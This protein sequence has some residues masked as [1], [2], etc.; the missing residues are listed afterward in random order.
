[1]RIELPFSVEYGTPEVVPIGEVI[2]SL[3]SIRTLIEE[4]G[5]NLPHFVDGLAVE[6]V[7][8]Y[9][10]SV[11]Q[12]SP[13]REVLFVAMFVAFQ[14]NLEKEVP[15]M[16]QQLTGTHVPEQFHTLI[17]LA[18]MIVLFYGVAYVRDVITSLH[19]DSRIK[20]QLSALIAE[21]AAMTGK[22]EEEIRKFLE[23]RY[24]VQGRAKALANAAIRFFRPSKSQADAP[25]S[26]GGRRIDSDIISDVPPEYAY[27]EALDTP[28]FREFPSV[29]LELHA[30]DRDRDQTGWAAIP[31]GISDKRLKMRLLD[32]VSPNEIWGKNRIK[33]DIVVKYDRNGVDLRAAEIH[34]TRVIR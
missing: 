30:Q 8:I 7:E 18:V 19:G 9:V 22:P 31:K 20:R 32:G 24:K 4:G 6:Q 17:T 27:D 28:T 33:G 5:G 3:I 16:I 10:R 11:S 13:L 34:L 2:D 29:E 12:E 23:E 1:M 25:I 15:E 26:I 21:L 14:K